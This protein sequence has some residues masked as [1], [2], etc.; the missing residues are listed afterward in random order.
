MFSSARRPHGASPVPALSRSAPAPAYPA[1]PATP[2]GTAAGLWQRLLINRNFALFSAGSFFSALGSWFL[3]VA[4][5]WLVFDL[6]DSAFVLGLST[7]MQL[8]PVFVL[9]FFGGVL[10]DRVDRRRLLLAGQA[11]TAGATAVMAGMALAGKAGVP[12]ILGLSL[13]L[14]VA[15]AVVWPTWQPFVKELVPDDRLRDAVAFNSARYHLTAV[16][17]PFLAGLLVA[18]AGAPACLV[19]AALGS[20]GV[21]LTTWRIRTERGRRARSAPASWTAALAEGTD[22]LRG[23][24][25]SRRLLLAT[26]AYGLC[27]M[28]YQALLPAVARDLLGTGAAGLGLLLALVGGGAV[29]GAL[30]TR[31]G[32]VGARPGL[33]MALFGLLGGAGLS[34]FAVLA[35]RA[36]GAGAPA[37]LV[38]LASVSL[39]LCGFGSNGYLT[40][41]NSTLQLRVPDRSE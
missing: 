14:G 28:P 36:Q 23:D 7:F 33:A 40:A 27:V 5:G 19:V 24:G 10:A 13:V 2:A 39:V 29:L 15:N 21:L 12:S 37:S 18:R 4:V 8:V 32:L 20:A 9:G 30:I 11:V 3:T 6:T 17:G 35:A 38:W 25:F 31:T 22:Y 41:G 1:G 26:G 34:A 16:V